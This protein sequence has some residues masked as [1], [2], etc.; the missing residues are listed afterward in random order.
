MV[1]RVVCLTAVG[2]FLMYS[3][4]NGASGGWVS[5]AN[6]LMY[7]SSSNFKLGIG[8]TSGGSVTERLYV[9]AGN[10][11]LDN[12]YYIKAK[13]YNGGAQNILQFQSPAA[14][15]GVAYLGNATFTAS[16][17][18]GTNVSLSAN[19]T[20]GII[21][22]SA[23]KITVGDNCQINCYDQNHEILFRRTENIMELR[24]Y[25]S[26]L[27]TANASVSSPAYQ[28]ILNQSGNLGIGTTTPGTYKLAVAG[29]MQVQGK[30]MMNNWTIEAPDYVFEK[31]Y[32]LPSLK[33]VEKNIAKVKHLPGVPSAAEMKK[34]VD[35]TEM[36]MT[37]L[38]KVEELT[39]Y[40][41]N[42]NKEIEH[43]KSKIK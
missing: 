32:K 39:L 19:T 6:D 4:S 41:I 22:L 12:N 37:L 20:S 27:F 25:G 35:L 28:M 21:S 38:K 33:E 8:V 9:K 16:V 1:K 3:A 26:I 43:L 17:V 30:I 13:D 31:G 14:G 11:L 2:L 24:E 29:D 15:I 42:Q 36:N 18:S 10:I 7:T 40:V 34:G 23:P 5:G